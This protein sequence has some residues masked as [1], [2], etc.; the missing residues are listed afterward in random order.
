M[1]PSRLVIDE[2]ALRWACDGIKPGP[3]YSGLIG[4][5]S[6]LVEHFGTRSRDEVVRIDPERSR[7]I[8]PGATDGLEGCPP[9]QR[10][11]VL[12][13]VVSRDEG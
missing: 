11:E 4:T 6:H 8:R 12:G 13:E 3:E 1:R 10:L 7:I 9:A 2:T 5:P